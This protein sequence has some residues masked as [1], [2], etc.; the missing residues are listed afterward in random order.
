MKVETCAPGPRINLQR[1]VGN[2]PHLTERQILTPAKA[3]KSQQT[4]FW[5]FDIDQ[6]RFSKW[7]AIWDAPSTF[8]HHLRLRADHYGYLSPVEQPFPRKIGQS[9]RYQ[10]QRT[11]AERDGP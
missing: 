4:S 1:S 3:H 2:D 7:R 8:I 10:Q 5:S 11:H 6:S 9:P